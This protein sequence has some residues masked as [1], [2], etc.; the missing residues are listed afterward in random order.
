MWWAF[1]L[2]SGVNNENN[3]MTFSL[4]VLAT[5]TATTCL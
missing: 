1:L 3:I 4:V 5:C 2:V